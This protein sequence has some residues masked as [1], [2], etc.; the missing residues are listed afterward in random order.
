MVRLMV[1]VDEETLTGLRARAAA[2]GLSPEEMATELLGAKTRPATD[3]LQSSSEWIRAVREAGYDTAG[4][5][6]GFSDAL[7][8]IS[9]RLRQEL[10]PHPTP[11][12]LL[13]EMCAIRAMTPPEHV[14]P[15][16]ALIRETRDA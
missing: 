12:E 4:E 1:S 5:A 7:E 14:T 3:P 15:A 11:G 16:E 9:A 2:R 8:K 10:N 13:Q 6:A